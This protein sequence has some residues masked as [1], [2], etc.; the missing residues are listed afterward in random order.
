V[1]L[2]EGAPAMVRFATMALGTD[3]PFVLH[4]ELSEGTME[5]IVAVTNLHR[6][7]WALLEASTPVDMEG[8]P[9]PIGH[10]GAGDDALIVAF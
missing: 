7:D 2:S 3:Q 6:G 5:A 10:A 4:R 8:P 1:L 9:L